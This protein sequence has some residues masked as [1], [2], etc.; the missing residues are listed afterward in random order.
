MTKTEIDAS[1]KVLVDFVLFLMLSTWQ[2]NKLNL[3]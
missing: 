3:T 2:K 1:P